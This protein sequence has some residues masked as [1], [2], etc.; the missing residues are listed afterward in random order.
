MSIW[1]IEVDCYVEVMTLHTKYISIAR[2]NSSVFRADFLSMKLKADFFSMKLR[3]SLIMPEMLSIFISSA[4]HLIFPG[5]IKFS[6]L[7]YPCNLVGLF[8]FTGKLLMHV[9][10]HLNKKR[11]K[12]II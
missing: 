11:A 9:K 8:R 1:N 3:L 12:Q 5:L 7:K 10:L 2:Y 4:L 6:N